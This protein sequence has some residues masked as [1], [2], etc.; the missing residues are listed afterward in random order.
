MTSADPEPA[1]PGTVVLSPEA[2][3]VELQ[4]ILAQYHGLL[5]TIV[6]DLVP[7]LPSDVQA[8]LRASV[9]AAFTG[10]SVSFGE[11][12]AE[13][14]PGAHDEG[15]GWVALRGEQKDLKKR[16]FRFNLKRF[17]RALGLQNI[18]GAVRHGIRAVKW[19]NIII[20][21]LSKELEKL[22]FVEVIK[23]FGEV[24]ET[25]LDHVLEGVEDAHDGG[26]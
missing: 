22:R 20:G 24:V 25:L 16:G 7:R 15:L 6:Q 21:S 10:V 9:E 3:R 12:N 8:E 1:T 13:L 2:E 26:G 4:A 11:L 5:T 23:E 18:E 19:G 14:N 17:Y